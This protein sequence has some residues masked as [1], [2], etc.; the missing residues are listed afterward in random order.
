M[1]PSTPAN[2][3]RVTTVWTVCVC[4]WNPCR[5]KSKR[6]G[7]VM[8]NLLGNQYTLLLDYFHGE[9]G[10]LGFLGYPVGFHGLNPLVGRGSPLVATACGFVFTLFWHYSLDDDI[11]RLGRGHDGA[12]V[13]HIHDFEHDVG[14]GERTVSVPVENPVLGGETLQVEIVPAAVGEREVNLGVNPELALV[15]VFGVPELRAPIL[16]E[17]AVEHGAIVGA[18]HVGH[19]VVGDD[20]LQSGFVINTHLGALLLRDAIELRGSG[21]PNGVA[22][23]DE[24]LHGPDRTA[25]L[26]A[27]QD[28]TYLHNGTHCRVLTTR[29]EVKSENYH[30]I[31]SS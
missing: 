7:D 25:K 18:N 8:V 21:F 17:G 9:R 3:T 27:P 22:V 19:Q 4:K 23:V 10:V 2:N 6:L 11:R 13:V 20:A 5:K 14:V 12:K 15:S 26:G 1:K 29:F 24:E 31:A 16:V 28:G 30:S